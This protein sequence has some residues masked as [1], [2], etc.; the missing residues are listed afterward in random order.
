M[1]APARLIL[2]HKQRTS[3][4]IRF[5]RFADGI[6]APEPFPKLAQVMD[7]GEQGESAAVVVH[8]AMLVG[9]VAKR[10][11]MNAG[12]IELESEFSAYVDT[13]EGVSRVYLG[14]FTSIDPPFEVAEKA[15]ANFISITEARDLS[16][17]ELELL[18]RA[19]ACIME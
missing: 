15:D 19:Y 2:V 11:G 12:D 16:S 5:L 18:R 14:Q 3:A 8:P 9:Q 10:L 6:A 17:T 1:T 4:R 13:P 7:I